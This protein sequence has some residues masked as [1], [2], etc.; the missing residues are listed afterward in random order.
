MNNASTK[1]LPRTVTVA[2]STGNELLRLGF[3]R[4]LQQVA[5]VQGYAIRESAAE[6]TVI[7]DPA[8]DIVI[9][10]IKELDE[11]PAAFIS[12]LPGETKVLLLLDQV[13]D[14][15]VP[16]IA[17]APSHGYLSKL[18]LSA[19]TLSD[20]LRGVACGEVPMPPDLARKLLDRAGTPS[21]RPE[22][23]PSHLTA[24]EQQVLTLLVD[25]LSNKEIAGR[26][27]LS[28]HSIKRYV[29]SI[30]AKLHSPN[31][32]SAAARAIREGLARPAGERAHC[33]S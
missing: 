13:A 2:F 17:A 12:R 11:S 21:A 29:T 18:D 24:R 3:E 25:G 23:V 16:Y 30:L 22:G 15:C 1:F 14:E 10:P 4:V 27:N 26:M 20:A 33:A 5:S 9:V 28:Q 32:T 19:Q 8:P 7:T 31:R 6:L